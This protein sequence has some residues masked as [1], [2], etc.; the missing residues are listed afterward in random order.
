MTDANRAN[1][2]A[3]RLL[4]QDEPPDASHYKEYRMKLENALTAA[5]RRERLAGHVAI[6]S[7]VVALALMF[8]GGSRLVGPFDPTDKDANWVS[9]T[10]G[11]VYCLA[12]VL[13]WVSLASYF[14]RFRPAVRDARERLRDA[15]ILALT[16]EIGELRK[17][18]EA[19]PRRDEPV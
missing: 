17:R 16:R 9:V 11:V 5:Q 7:F 8:V 13:F 1:R 4:Q 15:D 18:I 10:L 14:S 2:F 19:T 12:A 3:E 6:V